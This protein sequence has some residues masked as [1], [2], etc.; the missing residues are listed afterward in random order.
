LLSDRGPLRPFFALVDRFTADKVFCSFADLM[1]P[2]TASGTCSY[3]VGPTVLCPQACDMEM[4]QTN[5][6]SILQHLFEGVSQA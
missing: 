5:S 2:A 6:L 1:L 3:N 4:N